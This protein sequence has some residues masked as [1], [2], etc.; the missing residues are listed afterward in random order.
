LSVP[1]VCF[2]T[3]K[4]S[5]Q[6]RDYTQDGGGSPWTLSSR[7]YEQI[8]VGHSAGWAPRYCQQ[9]SPAASRQQVWLAALRHSEW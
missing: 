6:M 3:M 7:C 1:L 5:F 8:S 2:R 9:P 4:N